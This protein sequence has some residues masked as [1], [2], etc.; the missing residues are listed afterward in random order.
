MQTM[1]IGPRGAPFYLRAQATYLRVGP[2][3]LP[4]KRHTFLSIEVSYGLRELLPLSALFAAMDKKKALPEVFVWDEESSEPEMLILFRLKNPDAKL[5]ETMLDK[6]GRLL[7]G[8]SEI[9]AIGK[10]RVDR[11][12][13]RRFIHQ[14]PWYGGAMLSITESTDAHLDPVHKFGVTHIEHHRPNLG[15]WYLQ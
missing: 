7:I 14:F 13:I 6:M 8:C 5:L 11:H 3:Y 2:E 9:I 15:P 12:H 4:E 10:A 1:L